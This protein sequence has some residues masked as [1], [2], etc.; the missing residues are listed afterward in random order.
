VALT[1]NPSS[2]SV[3][4]YRSAEIAR[5]GDDD[6]LDLSDIISGFRC[7]VSEIFD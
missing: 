5:L 3:T 4:L 6:E 2:R 1:V 7:R